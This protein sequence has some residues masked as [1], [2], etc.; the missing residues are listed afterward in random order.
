MG[1]ILPG[2]AGLARGPTI[3]EESGAFDHKTCHVWSVSIF[4]L[5]SGFFSSIGHVI[6]I[7]P[8]TVYIPS[9]SP[10]IYNSRRLFA[11]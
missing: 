8:Y 6:I 5:H 4:H 1:F 11:S 9:I 3:V 7:V 10:R 2:C